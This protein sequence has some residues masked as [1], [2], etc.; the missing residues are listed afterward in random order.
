[1]VSHFLSCYTDLREW[2]QYGSLDN[3]FKHKLQ[4][5][6]DVCMHDKDM[7]VAE[8]VRDSLFYL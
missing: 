4:E 2:G 8:N 5:K 1:V 3:A 7:V 6:F